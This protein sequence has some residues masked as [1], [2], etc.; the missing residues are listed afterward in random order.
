MY[1]LGGPGVEVEIWTGRFVGV[2]K[3]GE[4]ETGR[5]AWKLG[6]QAET[7]MINKVIKIDERGKSFAISP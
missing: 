1:E 3:I 6:T 5:F 2:G 4:L 7:N